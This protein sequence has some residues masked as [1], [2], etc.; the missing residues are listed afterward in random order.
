MERRQRGWGGAARRWAARNRESG[1]TLGRVRGRWGW[2]GVAAGQSAGAAT[3][4]ARARGDSGK[5]L[6]LGEVAV[7]EEGA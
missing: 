4:G 7:M 6:G 1:R 3:R 2:R 5:G